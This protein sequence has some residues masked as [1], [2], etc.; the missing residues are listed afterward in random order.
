MPFAPIEVAEFSD[1]GLFAPADCADEEFMG[2]IEV[3]RGAGRGGLILGGFDG[4]RV[5][6]AVAILDIEYCVQCYVNDD[7]SQ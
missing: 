4:V 2:G 3:C 6:T 1:G 5:V 7:N